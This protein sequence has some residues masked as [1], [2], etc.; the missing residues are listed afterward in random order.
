MSEKQISQSN[1][2]ETMS[3]SS[4]ALFARRATRIVSHRWVPMMAARNS[5]AAT[6]RVA[7]AA[8]STNSQKVNDTLANTPTADYYDGTHM[9]E[10]FRAI[11]EMIEKNLHFMEEDVAQQLKGVIDSAKKVYAVE[12]P[13]GDAD[14]LLKSE[15][16]N[17]Q[18]MLNASPK[19]T[20]EQR[21]ELQARMARMKSLMEEAEKVIAVDAPDGESDAQVRD[22][23][24]EV[25]HIIEHAA[26]HED[27]GFVEY[28]HKMEHAVRKER[29]RDPEK[30]W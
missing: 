9:S 27:K 16:R 12:A 8:F 28:E 3:S 21:E 4:L 22:E 11:D 18:D 7:A 17:I 29:A 23:L 20:P 10:Q 6:S 25:N 2:K 24:R 15:L 19:T 26:S 5:R 14:W 1:P 13:D 30:D